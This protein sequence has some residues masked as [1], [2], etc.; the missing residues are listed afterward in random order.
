MTAVWSIMLQVKS[1]NCNDTELLR[2]EGANSNCGPPT[3]GGHTKLTQGITLEHLALVTRGNC[4]LGAIGH[5]LHKAISSQTG[6]AADIP[7]T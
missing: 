5:L 1:R 3:L 6:D 4:N 2:V 7:S